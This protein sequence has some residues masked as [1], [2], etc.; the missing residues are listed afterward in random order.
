MN[1]IPQLQQSYKIILLNSEDLES[2]G[3]Y[4]HVA[5]VRDGCDSDAAVDLYFFLLMKIDECS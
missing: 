3:Y 2:T 5:A 1:C 4:S